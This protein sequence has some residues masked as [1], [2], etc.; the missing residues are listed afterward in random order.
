M[1]IKEIPVK[2]IIELAAMNTMKSE[3]YNGNF[4]IGKRGL[5]CGQNQ[6]TNKLKMLDRVQR[7]IK[8]LLPKRMRLHHVTS[9]PYFPLTRTGEIDVSLLEEQS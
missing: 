9:V 6:M 3:A 2:D 8:I 4:K 5:P 7:K 1:A